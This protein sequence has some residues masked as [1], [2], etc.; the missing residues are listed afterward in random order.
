MSRSYKKHPGWCNR[1]PFMKKVAN[2]IVRH[3]ED[4]PNGMAY[5]KVF[6]SWSIHDYKSLIWDRSDLKYLDD[7]KS[8]YVPRRLP[9]KQIRCMKELRKTKEYREARSK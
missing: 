6:E 4:L 7:N 5:R 9:K 8:H 1:N 2:G 3:Y